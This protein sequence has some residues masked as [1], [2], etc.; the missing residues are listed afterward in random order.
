MNQRLEVCLW[1]GTQILQFVHLKSHHAAAII[2]EWSGRD[3][4]WRFLL[5]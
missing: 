4:S 2:K 3:N 5:S 1:M